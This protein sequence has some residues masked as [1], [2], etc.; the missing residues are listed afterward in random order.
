VRVLQAI[1]DRPPA[2]SQGLC[3]YLT[4][5]RC[6]LYG[7]AS[8][9]VYVY[10]FTC[11]VSRA[12]HLVQF[13]LAVIFTGIPQIRQLKIITTIDALRQCIHISS[14]DEGLAEIILICSDLGKR[15][16]K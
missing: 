5:Y 3:E 15:G 11:V 8:V 4:P 6:P 2:T 1:H 16:T 7:I 10:L 13:N 12:I 9:L 14:C